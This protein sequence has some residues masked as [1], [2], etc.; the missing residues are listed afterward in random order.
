ML[1]R[2]IALIVAEGDADRAESIIAWAYGAE[3]KAAD[4]EPKKRDGTRSFI[5]R[6]LKPSSGSDKER[7]EHF[8][9]K[10]IVKEKENVDYDAVARKILNMPYK[11]FLETP[12][13]KGAALFVKRRDGWKCRECGS[14]LCLEVHHLTY[15]HHG[16]EIHHLDDLVTVCRKCHKHSHGQ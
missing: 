3:P 2:V 6:Y 12:Y 13:W 7:V 11:D 9:G 14:T 8:I 5:S 1:A 4:K 16:D 10:C 15:E